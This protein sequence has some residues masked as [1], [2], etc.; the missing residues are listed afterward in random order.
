MLPKSADVR[1]KLLHRIGYVTTALILAAVLYVAFLTTRGWLKERQL[2]PVREVSRTHEG[3]FQATRDDMVGTGAAYL[4]GQLPA[5]EALHGDGVRFVA[6]PS[7]N[8]SHFAVSIDMPTPNSA[9]AEGVIWRFDSHNNY[10]PLGHRQFHMPA[11]A[12]RSLA[13]KIDTLT[14]GWTGKADMCLD[15][16]PIAF[17]RAR[18]PRITSGIGNCELHYEQIGQLVWNYL[19]RFASAEDL[20]TTGDWEPK[21]NVSNGRNQT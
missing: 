9:E 3:P 12:Y 15:G 2:S 8:R 18:G 6:M 1:P 20:P 16:T 11:P 21:A 4:F 10:A 14:D 7:F 13:K 5:L 19:R 17:E